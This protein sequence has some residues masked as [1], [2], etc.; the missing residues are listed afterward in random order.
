MCHVWCNSLWTKK[1]KETQTGTTLLLI[2]SSVCMAEK[3]HPER[4]SWW[5]NELDSLDVNTLKK[6]GL[7]NYKA[8]KHFTKITFKPIVKVTDSRLA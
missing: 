1:T 2:Y 3:E 7:N 6:N 8:N 5:P 4:Y